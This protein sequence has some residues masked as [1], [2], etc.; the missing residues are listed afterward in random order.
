MLEITF[1]FICN[2]LI[3]RM[4]L[5]VWLLDDRFSSNFIIFPE[6]C[7]VNEKMG[8]QVHNEKVRSDGKVGRG[9]AGGCGRGWVE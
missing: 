6:P 5:S 3:Q 1:V 9:E 4:S 7:R 2:C 8:Q